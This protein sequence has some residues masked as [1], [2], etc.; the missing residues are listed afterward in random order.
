MEF[1]KKRDADY[2][3]TFGINADFSAIGGLDDISAAGPLA[4]FS[5]KRFVELVSG[6]EMSHFYNSAIKFWLDSNL[7]APQLVVGQYLAM[8]PLFDWVGVKYLILDKNYFTTARRSDYLQLLSGPAALPIVYEDAQV[9]VLMSAT[10][11]PKA[12]FYPSVRSYRLD[13]QIAAL[14]SDP[15]LVSK[16]AF[17]SDLKTLA[18]GDNGPPT[19]ADVLSD[20]PN[21]IRVSVEAPKAG[22]LV[23]KEAFSPGWSARVNG[24]STEIVPVAGILQGIYLPAP[25]KY[26]VEFSYRPPGFWVGA[27]LSFTALFAAFGCLAWVI[28]GHIP[29]SVRF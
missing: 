14:R 23:V 13:D 21:Y 15:M 6:D 27:A 2:Y 10:A 18:Q 19:A 17:V 22:I 25:G 8:K 20:R 9:T 5:Y 16:W 7:P 1:L 3:R 24:N 4:P 26:E 28:I 29:R 12:E 11:K